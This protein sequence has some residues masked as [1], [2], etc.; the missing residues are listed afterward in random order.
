MPLPRLELSGRM[1]DQVFTAIHTAIIS[2]E[3]RAGTRLRIRDLA[4]E[5]GTSVMRVRGAIRRLEEMGL[6]EAEPY[7]GAVVREF[8]HTQL[9]ELY[10]GAPTRP[11]SSASRACRPRTSPG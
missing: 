7:R 8:T 11:R 5:L 1:G 4:D 3:L 10:T 2:G 6:V 9:L